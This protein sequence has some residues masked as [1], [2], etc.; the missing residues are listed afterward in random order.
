MASY[1]IQDISALKYSA[2]PPNITINYYISDYKIH[3]KLNLLPLMKLFINLPPF[4]IPGL[5]LVPNLNMFIYLPT[6]KFLLALNLLTAC[7]QTLTITTHSTKILWQHSMK[8]FQ[9]LS[10]IS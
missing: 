9:Y 10:F 5:L 4:Y 7:D 3:I 8:N 2:E 6:K 1:L